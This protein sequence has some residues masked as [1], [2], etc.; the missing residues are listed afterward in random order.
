VF[1]LGIGMVVVVASDEVHRTL[2]LLRTE[3]HRAVPIGEI[4]A[5]HGDVRLG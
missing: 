4:V 1:N 3:G 2:D 5:G